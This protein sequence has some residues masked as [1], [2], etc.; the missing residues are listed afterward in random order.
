MT[1]LP[2]R[3]LQFLDYLIGLYQWIIIAM[4]VLSWLIAFDVIKITNPMVR[5]VWDALNAVTEPLLRPIRKW[6][7]RV[8]P[9]LRGIDLAPAVL[10]LACLGLS[11]VV[12][13]ALKDTVCR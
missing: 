8:L 11:F 4:V 13:G 10:W 6:L 2:C 7:R 12:V 3:L 5:T 9:D 1:Q